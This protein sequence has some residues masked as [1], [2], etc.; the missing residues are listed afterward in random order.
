M[1]E[2]EAFD[3][4]TPSRV[5]YINAQYGL[6]SWLLTKDHKRIALLYLASITFFFFLGGLYAMMIRLELLTPQGDLLQ[7]TTYN[8][9][10]LQV[11]QD[12]ETSAMC[13]YQRRFGPD[14]INLALVLISTFKTMLSRSSRR[15]V[16]K[17]PTCSNTQT[18]VAILFGHFK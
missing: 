9:V 15:D 10:L 18:L 12:I 16:I 7:S 4:P 13:Y 2:F 17:S 8:K 5:N 3:L 1:K 11:G 6:K 14:V